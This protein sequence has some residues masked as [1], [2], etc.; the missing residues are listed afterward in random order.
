MK[1]FAKKC[2]CGAITVMSEDNKDGYNVS[3]NETDFKKHFPDL[4]IESGEWGSCNYCVN[5]WGIDLCG[6]GS[7]EKVGECQNEFDEC[8]SNVPAQYLNKPKKYALWN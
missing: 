4:E 3:M 6:C 7:G 8:R 1:L 2:S 5:H